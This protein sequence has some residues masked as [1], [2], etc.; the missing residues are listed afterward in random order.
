METI[1]V[2]EAPKGVELGPLIAPEATKPLPPA[3]L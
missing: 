1:S 2:E 3:V